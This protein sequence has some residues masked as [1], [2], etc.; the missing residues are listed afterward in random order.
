MGRRAAKASSPQPEAESEADVTLV[1]PRSALGDPR[2]ADSCQ[3]PWLP[4]PLSP[5]QP[6]H[7]AVRAS[8]QKPRAALLRAEGSRS[9]GAPG[10]AAL[11]LWGL[12][13]SHAAQVT[14]VPFLPLYC[15]LT[16]SA[17][18]SPHLAGVTH[19]FSVCPHHSTF[20]PGFCACLPTMLC[21]PCSSHSQLCPQ[22]CRSK[23]ACV[24]ALRRSWATPSLG[25]L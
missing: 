22:P 15:L 23:A 5:Y 3:P 16:S 13:S 8:S 7:T 18:S 9:S 4:D 25:S 21:G 11:R 10:V 20:Q 24:R 12:S 1:K 2:E 14:G 17:M 6:P 19:S